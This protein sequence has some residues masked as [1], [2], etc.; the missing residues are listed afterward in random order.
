MIDIDK[1]WVEYYLANYQN[2]TYDMTPPTEEQIQAFYSELI[3]ARTPEADQEVPNESE[4]EIF[5]TEEQRIAEFEAL[6]R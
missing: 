2:S 5:T 6:E 1:P 4:I 3:H